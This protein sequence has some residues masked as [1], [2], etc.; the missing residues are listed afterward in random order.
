M[1][2]SI[3]LPKDTLYKQEKKKHVLTREGDSLRGANGE[4]TVVHDGCAD[5][6]IDWCTELIDANCGFI[7]CWSGHHCCKVS[8]QDQTFMCNG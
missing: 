7:H 2:T 6:L 4:E 8:V 3:L 1:N 5:S